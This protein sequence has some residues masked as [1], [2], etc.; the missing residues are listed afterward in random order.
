MAGLSGRE[1][2]KVPRGSMVVLVGASGSGKSTFAARHFPR[3]HV[4]SSD[5]MRA[6]VADDPND[7]SATAAAFELLHTALG[8]RLARRRTTV[9]DATNVEGWA[10]A[11]LLA[12]ARRSGRPAIAIV[13]APS[14]E[15][16][17]A[18][19][20]SRPDPRPVA[21]IRRQ[22]RWLVTSL[23][24]LPGEGFDRVVVLD[25]EEASR[26]VEVRLEAG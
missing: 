21:A 16:I 11:R 19:N 24:A 1:V 5:E 12:I 26:A 10:R 9:V 15:V 23:D 14:L 4:L 22:Q 25:G 8:L 17:L 3:S 20:A 13:L 7:Q 6:I 2:I 18:R